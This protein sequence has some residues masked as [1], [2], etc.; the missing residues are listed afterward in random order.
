MRRLFPLFLAIAACGGDDAPSKTAYFDLDAPL[1][2][3]ATTWDLPW[4]SDLRLTADG[5][6]DLA[7]YPNPRS[8][9]ILNQ[10]LSVAGDRKGWPVQPV[11]Y[12][13]FTAPVLPRTLDALVPE[14][15]AVLIDLATGDK[16]P[17]VA[18]TLVEDPFVTSDLVAFAPRPGIVLAP[19]TPY[20]LVIRSAFAPGFAPAP[21]FEQLAQGKG[22]ADAVAL[23]EPLWPALDAAGIDDALVAT[24]FTTGDEVARVSNRASLARGTSITVENLALHGGDTYDGMCV[25]KGTITLP[26]FQRG[27]PPFDTDGRFELDA[28][29]RPVKQ[30]DLTVPL[31]LTIPKQPMPASGWPLYQYMHGSGGETIQ[32]VDRGRVATPGGMPEAGKGPG[33]V[34]AQRGIAAVSS[35]LPLNPERQPG[36]AD[37][38]Y[39]NIN[40]L[41]AFP[42]TFQQ[43]VIEQLILLQAL[44]NLT[45]P[46][47]AFA[48]CSMP[49]PAGG[50]HVFDASK[51][52]GGGQSMGGMYTN[53]TGA[54][55]DRWRALVP[56][57]AG[58]LWHVMILETEL[59]PGARSLLGTALGI[60]DAELSFVHP[61]MATLNLGWEIA[62]PI[63]YMDRLNRRPLFGARHIYQSV[64][65]DDENFPTTIYDA[66]VLAS[67]S[68]Q[69]GAVVW[70]TL[71]DAL[72][73]DGLDGVLAYPVKGN[74]GS[75]RVAVQFEGDGILDPH[76]IYQ[77]LDGVKHQYGCFLA[78]YVRDG[79]PTVPAPGAV[80]D[81]C[82]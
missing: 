55:T 42:Y 18:R 12:V 9:P 13:R 77:Q 4:P 20:A 68:Q 71:Q 27:M 33:W 52:M 28:D 29:D 47:E 46:Q 1:D 74:L 49:A 23:Y 56:T 17:I 25:L 54:L 32:L 70:P 64:P 5:A 8:V 19:N 76:Y 26:Q 50:A 51:M 53:M 65:K 79:V 24:V 36:A 69:A 59:V 45:I 38:A 15:D 31:V 35:A 58:G 14:T 41:I 21:A 67:G 80:L 81:P 63:A 57:G 75:T 44:T 43:G 7:G 34:V 73:T 37:Y 60:D 72:A 62:D 10:L 3:A 82:P 2:Q 6:P 61:G 66:A 48:G 22:P 39:L 11:M 16:A 40:N 78:T 30:R